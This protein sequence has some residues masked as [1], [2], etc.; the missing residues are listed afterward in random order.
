MSHDYSAKIIILG[1]A[2]SGKTAIVESAINKTFTSE[3]GCPTIGVEYNSIVVQV[4]NKRVKAMIWDTAGQ[5]SYRSVVSAYYRG[6]AG[7]V[8]VFDVTSKKSF[9]NVSYW[10]KQL[11]E[12]NAGRSLA[13]ILAAN[14]VDQKEKRLITNDMI[15]H[16]C[17]DK[18][19]QY[20]ET[21]ARNHKNTYLLFTQ[22]IN[23]IL[24]NNM[25]EI[26]EN[27]GIKTIASPVEMTTSQR[28]YCPSC[29]A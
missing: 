2:F 25:S 28:N 4:C 12:Q 8:I 29:M 14:K 22:I 3:E 15:T 20:L 7:A 6:C 10:L 11:K 23:N 5:E 21:S 13:I 1:D 26:K 17:Q 18:E 9:D 16:F 19:L 27:K 24:I